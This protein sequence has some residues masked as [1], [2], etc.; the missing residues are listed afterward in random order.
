MYQFRVACPFPKS[1][2]RTHPHTIGTPSVLSGACK[3]HLIA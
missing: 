1:K 3:A 2:L